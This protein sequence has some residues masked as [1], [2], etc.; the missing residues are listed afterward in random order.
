M[1]ANARAR[2]GYRGRAHTHVDHTVFACIIFHS[3]PSFTSTLRDTHSS[4]WQLFRMRVQFICMMAN[5][6]TTTTQRTALYSYN[7]YV[8]NRDANFIHGSLHDDLLLTQ[9][10]RC[11]CCIT[12]LTRSR[13]ESRGCNSS[14]RSQGGRGC[15][16]TLRGPG[17]TGSRGTGSITLGYQRALQANT[18]HWTTSIMMYMY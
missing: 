14:H 9:P 18:R 6:N 1:C 15:N 8:L 12:E 2:I 4:W 10:G 13:P 16:G 11:R 5:D 7:M 3:Q 17:C